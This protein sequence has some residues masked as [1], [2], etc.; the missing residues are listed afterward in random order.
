MHM[1]ST[2]IT[3]DTFFFRQ[4]GGQRFS[5]DSI[6][7]PWE[8]VARFVY[9]YTSGRERDKMQ[10]NNRSCLPVRVDNGV[11]AKRDVVNAASERDP[12]LLHKR[13]GTAIERHNSETKPNSLLYIEDRDTSKKARTW[14][15]VKQRTCDVASKWLR[16]QNRKTLACNKNSGCTGGKTQMRETILTN[17]V[18]SKHF[19]LR[20]CPWVLTQDTFPISLIWLR[21]LHSR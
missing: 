21:S 9:R 12:K 10:N 19:M 13:E 20:R 7:Q 15:R 1:H 3:E 16:S 14:A 11:K 6:T 8:D 17:A 18:T 5:Q 2:A 4:E